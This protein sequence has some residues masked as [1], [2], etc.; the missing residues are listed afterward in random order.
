VIHTGFIHDFSNFKEV[1]EIDR[2]AIEALGSALVASATIKDR[3]VE[4][5]EDR[6]SQDWTAAILDAGFGTRVILGK[7]EP[8][9]DTASI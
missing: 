4:F 5:H 7:L 3:H 6:E 2:H 1:C 9:I 8:G